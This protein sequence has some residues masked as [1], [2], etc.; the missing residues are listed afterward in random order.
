MD[1]REGT[2]SQ[3]S[4][5]MGIWYSFHYTKFSPGCS[6][7]LHVQQRNTCFCAVWSAVNLA[8]VYVLIPLQTS[9][10]IVK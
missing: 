7:Q 9:H 4:R 8:F 3:A 1:L 2:S 6:P 5:F 10:T